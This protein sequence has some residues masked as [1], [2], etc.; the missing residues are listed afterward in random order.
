VALEAKNA[1]MQVCMGNRDGFL[2][3]LKAPFGESSENFSSSFLFFHV[4]IACNW[5][6]TIFSK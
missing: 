6:T 4:Q 1:G 5:S 3:S 2:D